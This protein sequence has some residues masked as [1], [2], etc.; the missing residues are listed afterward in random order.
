MNVV[1]MYEK[2]DSGIGQN[3]I[4][5]SFEEAKLAKYDDIIATI[6]RSL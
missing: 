2:L 6:P 4:F 3:S 5:I 1:N